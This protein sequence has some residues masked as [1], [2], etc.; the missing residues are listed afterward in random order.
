MHKKLY[1]ACI[2][3]HHYQ[4]ILPRCTYTFSFKQSL[5]L[6]LPLDWPKSYHR[7]KPGIPLVIAGGILDSISLAETADSGHIS[8]KSSSQAP[9]NIYQSK[10][11]NLTAYGT[12]VTKSEPTLTAPNTSFV[13]RLNPTLIEGSIPQSLF[14]T[15]ASFLAN[16]PELLSSRY[17]T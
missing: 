10:K 3:L 13:P 2:N 12:C 7:F 16:C 14:A 15:N 17:R 5:P 1:K 6:N 4:I 8:K 9:L 11:S